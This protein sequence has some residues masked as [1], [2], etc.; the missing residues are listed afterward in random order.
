MPDVAIC[1]P[2]YRIVIECTML[3][4]PIGPAGDV[5][6]VP[7]YFSGGNIQSGQSTNPVRGGGD[8]A[9]M[10]FDEKMIHEG[11]FLVQSENDAALF[12]YNGT[13]Q[14]PDGTYD[15]LLEGRMP[16]TMTS[17]LSVRCIAA[18]PQ[19]RDLNRLH[20]PATGTVDIAAG[21]LKMT[22]WNVTPAF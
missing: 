10:H 5:L 22:V 21:I 19:W 8:F 3:S 15:A 12:F 1:R 16:A 11:R 13:S 2:L 17:A 6:Y 14:G 18:A 20:L 4:R 9:A 7:F